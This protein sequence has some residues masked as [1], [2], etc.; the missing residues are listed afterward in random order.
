MTRCSGLFLASL[1]GLTALGCGHDEPLLPPAE[2]PSGVGF[3]A[4][5]REELLAAGVGKYLGKFEPDA[6]LEYATF[7]GYEFTP[8]DDGPTC[9]YGS[10]FH[11]SVRDVG[12]D[13]LLVYLQGGG[14]CWSDLCAANETA[15]LGIM[16]LA[17]TDADAERNPPLAGFNVVFVSYC[18]GSVFS[19]DNVVLGSG[20]EIVRRHRGLANL[21][22]ALDVARA[23]F[24]T[25][26][27][28]VL[29]G[30]SAGG[31]GTILGTAVTRLAYPDTPLFVMNDAGPGVTNPDD[32]SLMKGATDEWQAMKFV[33][34]SCA[35]CV[36]SGQLTSVVDWALTHDPSLRV[37]TFCALEDAIIGN[38][39]L[40]MTGPVFSKVLMAETDKVHA[41]HPG[42]YQRF[43]WQ[44]GA[45]T[46]VM[47][48]YYDLEIEG[49]SLLAF[50]QAM[51]DG[52]PAYRDLI[53]AP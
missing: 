14:A 36:E 22:A 21:S 4:A 6:V 45:H 5:A 33:P 43:F 8:R 53:E 48:G 11:V 46:A 26:R 23:R 10:P 41:K 9:L 50:I 49:T 39:F 1:V 25:P 38:V 44:G 16:P 3:D 15:S 31:Y 37:A 28:L 52:S 12:S 24:P 42:R 40:N 29:A 51:L 34:E 32:L 35:G 47:A 13:D 30:S 7:D 19:G 20:G 18:D 27:R 2:P 17:W